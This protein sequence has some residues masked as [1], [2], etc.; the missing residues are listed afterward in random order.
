MLVTMIDA[1]GER[2]ATASCCL[3]SVSSMAYVSCIP[4]LAG[5]DPA[6]QRAA[7]LARLDWKLAIAACSHPRQQQGSRAC[8]FPLPFGWEELPRSVLSLCEPDAWF[9]CN[10][11]W[12]QMARCEAWC[13]LCPPG[14]NTHDTPTRRLRTCRR[15]SE[16]CERSKVW[17]THVF[18][19]CGSMDGFDDNRA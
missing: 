9:D 5:A 7:I 13:D 4:D 16:T 3:A 14:N 12:W 17:L 11:E 6:Q 1:M 2:V 19:R 8:G 18:N 15:P 10:G